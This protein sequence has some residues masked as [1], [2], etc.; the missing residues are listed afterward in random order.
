MRAIRLGFGV[1]LASLVLVLASSAWACVPGGGG[2]GDKAPSDA[3]RVSSS[4]FEPTGP[5]ARPSV[6]GTERSQAPKA[7]AA[8][9]GGGA[10]LGLAGVFVVRRGRRSPLGPTLAE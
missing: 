9:A 6:A 5:G 4:S 2:G 3:A 8:L 1:C 10:V 7:L